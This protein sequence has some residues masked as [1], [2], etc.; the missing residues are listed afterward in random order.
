MAGETHYLS[1][2]TLLPLFLVITHFW[3]Q[4]LQWAKLFFLRPLHVPLHLPST[5][6]PTSLLANCYSFS[7]CIFNIPSFWKPSLTP[8]SKLSPSRIF[9]YSSFHISFL[10]EYSS[11]FE[12]L[13]LVL[14]LL[15]V[16]PSR[17]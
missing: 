9:S 6:I 11:Y 16:F 8:R 13:F 15:S 5:H 2:A 3:P 12:T 14:Y 17:L 1:P 10:K 7:E 4:C